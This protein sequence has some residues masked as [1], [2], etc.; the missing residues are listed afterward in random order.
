MEKQALLEA[1]GL[2]ER[3]AR[4]CEVVQFALEARRAA[5]RRQ[6]VSLTGLG[7]REPTLTA[8]P[9]LRDSSGAARHS[10]LIGLISGLRLGVE[11]MKRRDALTLWERLYLPQIVGGL[12]VIIYRFWRNLD[13][14]RA[15]RGRSGDAARAR[16]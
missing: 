1:P 13:A 7:R 9:R 12:M 5:A 16:R 15:A 6:V 8:E 10:G 2:A 3:G 11:E 4:L 14:A